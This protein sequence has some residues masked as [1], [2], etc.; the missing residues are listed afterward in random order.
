LQR[1]Y[2]R[3]IVLRPA[4]AAAAAVKASL[5]SDCEHSFAQLGAAYK[6]EYNND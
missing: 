2:E 4:A 5:S 6:A 1:H 3:Y